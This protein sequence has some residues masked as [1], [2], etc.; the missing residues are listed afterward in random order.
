MRK[1][2]IMVLFVLISVSMIAQK[3]K[4]RNENLPSFG[5]VTKEDLELKQCDFDANA[6]AMILVEDGRIEAVFGK[7]IEMKKRVRIKILD[8]KGLDWANVKL[9]YYSEGRQQEILSLSAQTYNLDASGKT[10]VTKL[11]KKLVYDKKLN[12]RLTE[13][14]F[15]FPDVK[16][17]SIIEYEYKH[18]GIGLI[19]WYFQ[20]SIPVR[21]S[22]FAIDFPE[23][24]EVSVI[25]FCSR[26]YEAEVKN[27]GVRNI[28]EY[29]MSKVPGLR[30]EPFVINEDFYRDRLETKITAYYADGRRMN[31]VANWKEV[32]KSLMED[33]D[34]GVQIKRNIPKT[35][36]LDVKLNSLSTPYEKMKCIYKYVQD[37]MTWNESPGI[38]ALDGVRSAWKDKKGTVGEINLI[39]VNFLKE[40]GINADPVLVSTHEHGIVNA[41]DA[42]TY[43]SSGIRQFD[44][45]VAYVEM[46]NN[47]YVLDATQKDVPVHLIPSDIL[48]TEGL[49]IEKLET[50][51]WGWK[52]LWRDD[53]VAKNI[54]MIKGN[55]EAEGNL[56]G[57]IEITSFDY[58]RLSKLGTARKGKEK[59]IERYAPKN[60]SNIN[61]EDV[62]FENLDSDSLPLIQKIKFKQ[63]LNAAGEYQY[64]STNILTGL[65]TN[66]FVADNRVTD[67]FFGPNQSYSIYGNF[68]APEG[69]QF[70]ELPK[71]IKMIMPDTSIVISRVAQVFN[72]TL[73]TKIVIDFKRPFYPADQY[74]QLQEF[75]PRL[76]EIL[77]EQFVIRKK[78]ALP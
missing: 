36:E 61:V 19:D 73:Q 69:Y 3:N 11:D 1:L 78:N 74:D 68:Q 52:S 22:H 62:T 66:P 65:E 25:P 40:A 35:T 37:N 54:I 42:G 45:V 27:S 10:V 43:E 4:N 15:T 34:F 71:N 76:F 59:Y 8:K 28:K 46:D 29:S 23:E 57:Q 9:V 18:T 32:I 38:W 47:V 56:N 49:V 41:A 2:A 26:Q 72:N 21:Y 55:I 16:I 77:N 53:L 12:K 39:L 6:E 50:Q 51:E 48:M 13:K 60:A 67:V 24:I 63:K 20:R 5:D 33:E 30:N 64:F 44:K 17:G 58:A 7:G 75:Y 31:R 70:E 14:T